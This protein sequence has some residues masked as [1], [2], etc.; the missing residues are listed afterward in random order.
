MANA[1]LAAVSLAAFLLMVPAATARM[2]FMKGS[3][4]DIEEGA[5]VNTAYG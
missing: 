4:K 2:K 1:K 3:A 5:Q